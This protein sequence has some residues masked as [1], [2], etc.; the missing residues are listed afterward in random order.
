MQRRWSALNR[1]FATSALTVALSVTVVATAL[2]APQP[3]GDN[4]V[5]TPNAY[6]HASGDEPWGSTDTD[7]ALSAVFGDAWDEEHFE[8]VDVGTGPGGLFA[9]SVSFI[10]LDGSDG[11]AIELEAF[12][13]TNE[14]ALKAFVDRGGRLFV[15]SAPNEGDGVIAYDG[16]QISDIDGSSDYVVAANPSHPIF[17][18]PLTP[19]GTS[20]EGDSFGHALVTGP[21]LT[22]LIL[23]RVGD[24]D[25]V[26][27]GDPNAVVLAEYR[28]GNGLTLIGGITLPEHQDPDPNAANLWAN[29]MAYTAS[30]DLVAP[31][32]TSSGCAS[33]TQIALKAT[34]TGGS[35][36]ASIR[37]SIDGGAEQTVPADASGNAR[38][39]VAPGAHTVVFRAVDG[40]GNVQA[41]PG[42]VTATC[43]PLP[44]T[45]RP[46]VTVK[47]LP[48]ACVTKAFRLRINVRDARGVK[49][50]VVRRDGKRIAKRVFKSK[51]RVSVRVR[52]RVR[53]LEAGRHKLKV[54]AEDKAGNRKTVRRKFRRCD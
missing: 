37:Y 8:T 4:Q 54:T 51:K 31:S 46:K 6:L 27:P 38:V 43:A 11:S 17:V 7:V 33:A 12:L 19:A 16:K 10:F 21:G 13:A 40:A 30:A 47:G 25:G 34:D 3:E 9:P 28:S 45:K 14:P 49:R 24:N 50:L 32:A 15:N 18:G 26:S 2:A 22:P 53:N 44:D 52:V 1:M 42:T 39:T 5:L 36:A 48:Q 20:F 41:T 23:R 35:G 29:I